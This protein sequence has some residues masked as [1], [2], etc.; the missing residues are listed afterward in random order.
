MARLMAPLVPGTISIE[1]R[2]LIDNFFASKFQVGSVS[3]LA[4]GYK[5]IEFTYVAIAEPLAVVVLPY[6]SDLAIKQQ[7]DTLSDTVFTTLRTIILIFT[8]MAVCLFMLRYPVVRVLFE[9]GAFDAESTQLT[10]TALTYYALGLVSFAVEI[11]LAQTYFSLSD[12]LTP[13]MFE[14][15]T[16]A[17]HIGL[18][19]LLQGNL[20]HGA[21]AL[22]FT[23]SKTLKVLILY[24]LLTRKL[25]DI[26][27][28]TNVGFL[29]KLTLAVGIMASL[30]W[31]YQVW[32]VAQ[33]T[34]PAFVGQ[35]L[36]IVTSGG[37]GCLVFFASI[38]LLKVR[39]IR[40]VIRSLVGFI[41]QFTSQSR[42]ERP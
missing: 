5:L 16:L 24:G 3:A 34:L 37:F 22:A 1:S 29:A 26:Q 9:R 23:F 27:L 6:F 18:I 40:L 8:P 30:M 38:F 36:L 2:R 39:E 12:T 7:R 4:F 17:I 15:L 11:L 13:A 42:E 35:A 33:F 31:G 21:I 14:V 20:G 28:K 32:F 19:L 41:E 10:V 25:A